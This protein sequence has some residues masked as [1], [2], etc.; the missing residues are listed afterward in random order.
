MS[1]FH[2]I[3]PWWLLGLLPLAV[4]A[5][6]FWRVKRNQGGWQ[7]AIAPHLLHLLQQQSQSSQRAWA[8]L[9]LFLAMTLATLAL[10]GPSWERLPQP[11][12][13]LKAGTVVVMDMSLSMRATDISPNRLTQQRFKAI[14][15]VQDYLDGEIGL[16][17]YAG[18]AHIISPLSTD[19][20]NLTNLIRA[21]SPEIMP[22]RG[23]NPEAAIR[24]AD[25]LL[26]DAGYLAGDII[27]LTDGIDSLDQRL[28]IDFLRQTEHRVSIM[29]VGTPA[30][31]PIELSDG[32]YLRDRNNQVVIPTYSLNLLETIATTSAG[33]FVQL[34]NDALDLE[35]LTQLSPLQADGEKTDNEAGDQWADRGAW[36]LLPV[37]ILALLF[38]QKRRL[39]HILSGFVLV[40]SSLIVSPPSFAQQNEPLNWTEQLWQT[41]Y[42]Q[43]DQALQRGAFER[44]QGISEDAWQRGTAAYRAGN[45]EAALVDFS[46][47]V[48]AA[49]FYN[50]GNALFQLERYQEAI[51]AYD[52]ALRQ[53]PNWLEAEENKAL[54]EQRLA[55]QQAEQEQQQ[56][57]SSD[58][59]NGQQQQQSSEQSQ[60]DEQQQSD[61][62]QGDQQQQQQQQQTEQQQEAESTAEETD[63][64]QPQET[65]PDANA[66][67][68]TEEQRQQ[69]EQ[70][71]NRIQDDPAIL[72]RN[73]MLRE[74]QRRQQQNRLPKGVEKE[75]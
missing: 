65:M 61:E 1:E 13:Q 7:G 4:L 12:Y 51:M 8:P 6:Q 41:P 16:I 20:K 40:L 11:V 33:N 69:M 32:S 44:A 47:R 54:A 53:R 14:D 21:L 63:A 70:W 64:E 23:S 59:Q 42:Q 22:I 2:F 3:R 74:A 50:Q 58:D 24:L 43:A 62:Q 38:A 56:G 19:S 35:R 57:E 45:Y 30:G 18:D 72:L 49:G 75:W 5:W 68:L 67:A 34:R 31:A 55:E 10:A 60:Q 37:L 39:P 36:L 9:S 17:A 15:L 52:E 66:E 71:L 73:K 28:I 48:D 46:Q 27:W 26:S 25:R 29:A